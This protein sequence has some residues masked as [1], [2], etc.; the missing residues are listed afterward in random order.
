VVVENIR[1]PFLVVGLSNP[2]IA[3]LFRYKET[4]KTPT[5]F[6]KGLLICPVYYD[7][8]TGM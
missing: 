5:D 6:S 3:P 2:A 8:F 1:K 7:D 4:K